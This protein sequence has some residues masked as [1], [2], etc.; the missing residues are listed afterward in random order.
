VGGLAPPYD[1]IVISH[2]VLATG[3]KPVGGKKYR[4]SRCRRCGR[5]SPVYCDRIR[6]ARNKLQRKSPRYCGETKRHASTVG[7]RK[8]MTILHDGGHRTDKGLPSTSRAPHARG[9][10]CQSTSSSGM[11]S[12]PKRKVSPRQNCGPWQVQPAK[13][14]RS[15]PVDRLN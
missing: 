4:P 9:T 7:M 3:A 12:L 2:F 1:A 15:L 10:T 6:P 13:S 5:Y 14:H 8:R 11:G